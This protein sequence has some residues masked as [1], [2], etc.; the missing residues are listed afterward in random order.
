MDFKR[1][2]IEQLKEWLSSYESRPSF[3]KLYTNEQYEE[4]QME[5]EKRIDELYHKELIEEGE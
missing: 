4:V 5:Y 2:N 3:N 1:L